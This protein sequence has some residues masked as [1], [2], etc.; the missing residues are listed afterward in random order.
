MN[1]FNLEETMKSKYSSFFK[2]RI[3]ENGGLQKNEKKR[4]LFLKDENLWS[5]L[6]GNR[7]FGIDLA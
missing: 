2:T 7:N 4:A 5:L 3:S 6:I 1:S